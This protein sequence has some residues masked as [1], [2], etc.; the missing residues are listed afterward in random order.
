MPKIFRNKILVV[1]AVVAVII[2][3]FII[4]LFA[5]SKAPNYE[6][7]IVKRGTIIQEVSVTG[8]VK[9]TSSADLAFEKSGRIS[10]INAQVGDKVRQG[11]II[12]SLENGDIYALLQQAQANLDSAKKGARPEE[13]QIAQTAVD[14]ARQNLDAGEKKAEADLRS[15]YNAAVS[16]IQKSVNIAKTTLM[17]IS[18]I[19]YSH[20]TSN[21]SIANAKAIAVSILLGQESAGFWT[22]GAISTLT[23]GAFGEAQAIVLNP[24]N[25][26]IDKALTDTVSA[27]QKV[28][29]ALDSIPTDDL[30]STEKT[31]L[32]A[33]KTNIDTETITLSG[34]QQAI[35]V[36]KSTNGATIA[37]LRATL[38]SS[39][40]QLVLEQAGSTPEQIAV[41]EANVANYQAQ[42]AKTLIRSPIDGIITKQDAKVGEIAP[43][44]ASIVSVMS[45]NKF[46]IEANVP[47]ADIA[48]IKI[49]D[50]SQATLDAYGS[51]VVFQ[52]R[53]VKI[54]PAE[55]VIEG[56]PTYKTTL[57]FASEDNR[58][59]SGM[60]ANLDILTDRRDNALTIPQR[61]LIS[62]DGNKT[63]KI[64][65]EK[66]LKEVPV[67][68]GLRGS[69]GTMEI[70][71]GLQ[72]GDKVVI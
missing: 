56:V 57:Q 4:Y 6:I 44:A 52:T 61:A 9:P 64:L 24:T 50:V 38:K 48:K 46:E 41:Q 66:A 53:V 71:E 62:K 26:A 16:A 45:A 63:V 11:D 43:V 69:D 20:F 18:D 67:K 27:L 10:R 14:N 65:V 7:F 51:D 55:I 5:R 31:T 72:E 21:D 13:I 15:A 32:S 33:N 28:R 54:D 17:D 35:N 39:Q 59:K 60:T 2:L 30:T 36:Q 34:K 49:G 25:S 22:S 8:E 1:I 19:Q 58:I 42:L 23:G 40:D 70:L 37:S 12:V 29:A 3:A 68:A 47:E